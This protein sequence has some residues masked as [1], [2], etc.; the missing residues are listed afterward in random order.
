MEEVAANTLYS[1]VQIPKVVSIFM[2][3]SHPNCQSLFCGSC[4][5]LHFVGILSPW[6]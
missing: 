5:D 1:T 6:C 2:A 3:D 4:S